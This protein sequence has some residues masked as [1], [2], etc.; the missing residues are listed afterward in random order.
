MR[1]VRSWFFGN[2]L[3]Q[4][5]STPS[6][7]RDISSSDFVKEPIPD[8][9][10]RYTRYDSAGSIR[11]EPQDMY[12]WVDELSRRKLEARMGREDRYDI[13]ISHRRMNLT[14]ITY[15][16]IAI[17]GLMSFWSQSGEALAG[18]GAMN[19]DKEERKRLA[20]L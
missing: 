18:V 9:G 2:R 10:T 17:V 14:P 12:R 20:K 5:T 16:L 6:H 11:T 13:C 8:A 7:S 3:R 19:C 1:E 15:L 4:L